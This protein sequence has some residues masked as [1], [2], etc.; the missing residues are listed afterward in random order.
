MKVL[1]I[2]PNASYFILC[3]PLVRELCRRGHQ[4]LIGLLDRSLKKHTSDRALK[5]CLTAEPRC[6]LRYLQGRTDLWWF[7]LTAG[8]ELRSY[9]AYF[10]PR[11]SSPALARRWTNYLPF[12]LK[13]LAR[14]FPLWKILVQQRVQSLLQRVE[15]LTTPDPELIRCLKEIAPDVL[16]ACPYIFGRA[17]EIEYVKAAQSLNIPTVVFIPSWDN[18][19]TKG[20]F[21]LIPDVTLVWNHR[22]HQEAIEVHQLPGEKVVITGAPS[23]D[24]WF[25]MAPSLDRAAFCGRLGLDPGKPYIVYLCSSEFITGDETTFVAN[26]CQSLKKNGRAGNVNVLIRPHPFN[27]RIWKDFPEDLA[28]VWPRQGHLPDA[29]TAQQD[30]YNTLFYSE[31]VVGVNTSAFLGAAI[32]DRPCI[33]IIS[34]RYQATQSGIGHFQHLLD[35][36]FLETAHTFDEAAAIVAGIIAGQDGKQEA[37]HRFVRD[38]IRPWGLKRPAAEVAARVIELAGR[39]LGGKEII[40]TL[41]AFAG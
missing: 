26:F 29:P 9:A 5:A 3:D 18:L 24:F 27:T 14:V 40:T 35:S 30:Y 12:P 7:F 22:L 33:T 28:A 17:M 31:A 41:A 39:R 6:E 16:V 15:N 8:R 37:R 13:Y 23:L 20:T 34:E 38:F 36:Q 32:L 4:A 19:T 1:F 10:H 25:T 11:H 21:S 2:N